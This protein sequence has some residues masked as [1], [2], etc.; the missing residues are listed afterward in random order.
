MNIADNIAAKIDA[1]LNPVHVE[2]I[3]E[4]H[5]HSGPATES[6]F[7][8][9]VVSERFKDLPLIRQH[10]LVNETLRDE[11]GQIHALALH[12][13]TPEEWFERGGQAPTSPPCEGGGKQ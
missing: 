4:S 10:R 6:H 2:I 8:L 13:Y 3:N 11:L 9:T 5:M 1:T 12:T 7:K